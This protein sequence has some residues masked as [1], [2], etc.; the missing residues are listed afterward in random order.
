MLLLLAD[1]ITSKT[2]TT[3]SNLRNS[4]ESKEAINSGD[5]CN[6]PIKVVTGACAQ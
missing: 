2:D 3:I 6:D 4:Y 1:C 5:S